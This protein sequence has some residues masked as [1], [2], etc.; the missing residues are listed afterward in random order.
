MLPQTRLADAAAIADRILQKVRDE[1]GATIS[2]G[3]AQYAGHLDF[4]GVVTLA[5]QALYAAKER[6]RDQYMV[7]EAA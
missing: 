4:E 1:T 3:V 7:A 5:D 6:G 2:A